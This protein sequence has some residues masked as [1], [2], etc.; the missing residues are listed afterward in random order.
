MHVHKYFV[1]F[2][3]SLPTETACSLHVL[4]GLAV[5]RVLDVLRVLHIINLPRF[6]ITLRQRTQFVRDLNINVIFCTI[7]VGTK[8]G[9]AI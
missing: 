4:C 3:S 8:F 5:L 6:H 2:H 7:Y 9:C 1:D